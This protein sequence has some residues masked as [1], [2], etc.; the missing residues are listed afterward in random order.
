[1]A[2]KRTDT[3]H[4]GLPG[5]PAEDVKGV[6]YSCEFIA[7]GKS[8]GARF[9]MQKELE[10]QDSDAEPNVIAPRVYQYQRPLRTDVVYDD[11]ECY[12]G[13]NL[14]CVKWGPKR[15][16][17]EHHWT[18]VIAQ[19][20][21]NEKV[22]GSRLSCWLC[23]AWL[24]EHRR[25]WTR[26]SWKIAQTHSNERSRP[27]DMLKNKDGVVPA[28]YS[29]DNTVTTYTRHIERPPSRLNMSI[30]CCPNGCDADDLLQVLLD[31]TDH[32]GRE[33]RPPHA[34]PWPIFLGSSTWPLTQYL[35]GRPIT[36]GGPF[37]RYVH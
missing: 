24:S 37:N 36:I 8:S 25:T 35:P 32:T 11:V 30:Y 21:P 19:G 2:L 9:Y 18:P 27:Y 16:T 10:E 4:E 33:C 6:A 20:P 15:G 29:A 22:R 3:A 13:Y 7:L 14:R 34:A 28:T 17:W 31:K 5:I 26:P 1:M 23:D 12:P